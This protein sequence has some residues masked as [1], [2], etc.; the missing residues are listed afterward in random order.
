MS[1][2][3]SPDPELVGELRDI[4][5]KL[6]S[7]F[8]RATMESAGCERKRA[9]LSDECS[10]LKAECVR[11]AGECADWQGKYEA[12]TRALQRCITENDE[13]RARNKWRADDIARLRAEN[14]RLRQGVVS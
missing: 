4:I 6:D 13:L 9:A 3:T 7:A 5:A 10:H 12:A 14:I 11:L 1:E 8:R 2:W